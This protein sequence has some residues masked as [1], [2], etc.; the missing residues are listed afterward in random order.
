MD[1]FWFW[2][3]FLFQDVSGVVLPMFELE[4]LFKGITSV[5]RNLYK[6]YLS[7][8][9][10]LGGL[11]GKELIASEMEKQLFKAVYSTVFP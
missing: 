7:A 8:V 1:L 6:K 5:P 9:L 4:D 2:Y 11:D 10:K 3:W